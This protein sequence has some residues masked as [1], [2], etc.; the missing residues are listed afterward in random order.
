MAFRFHGVGMIVYGERG[1]QPDGSFVTT[2][3]FAV[4]YVPLFP[5]ISKR[6]SYTRISDY[7][8][9]DSD[10]YFVYEMLPLDHRQVLSVYGW[11]AGIIAPLLVWGTFQ[12]ALTKRLGDEDLAAGLCLLSSAVAFV[13]PFLLRRWAKQRKMEEWKRQRLGM[14]GRPM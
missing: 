5:I 14:H 3:F 10:G 8:S 9:Y 13:L 11:F 4:A 2:Q 7:S 1:Y 12:D 6:I